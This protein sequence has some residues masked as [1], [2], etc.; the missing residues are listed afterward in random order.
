MQL[1]II[2][3]TDEFL[4]LRGE[5]N[6]LLESSISDCV[7]LTHEWLSAWWK[8]MAGGRRLS[9]LTAREGGKLI[10]ILPMAEKPAQLTRMMP[11]TVE[12]LGSGVIGSD[13]LDAIVARG[14]ESEV[15]T[16]LAGHLHSDGRMLQLS[17]LRSERSL[18]SILAERLRRHAWTVVEA[19]LNVC[20]FIDLRGHTWESYVA[21][22]GPAVRKNINRYLRNLPQTFDMRIDCVQAPNEAETALEIAVDLH[23][24]RW[25]SRGASQAF[26]S[27]SVLAFH[28][29]FVRL[30]AE[31]GWL[32]LLILRL[33][34]RP[35]A[36][37][38][39]LR[40][41]ATFYFYQSGFDPEYSKHSVGAATMGL[42]IRRAIEDGA[43]EYDFL[44]GDEEYKFHWARGVRDLTRLELHPPQT[45]A[46]IYKHA[47]ALNRAARQMARRV[48]VR[49]VRGR[50]GR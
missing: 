4:N 40:Y 27:E 33:N 9:I 22:L 28:R 39:G 46:W 41:G 16:E 49:D 1:A 34:D 45:T 20:P 17:Q 36:A 23:R 5:W 26:Q 7:F 30:A 13:Y 37:L 31:C 8:H 47:I 32:R 15:M 43:A 35:V 2:Q 42:A 19:K 48:L 24:K 44:H 18:A 12:F 11:C 21:T 29:E 14:R 6:T 10:G 25:A 50:A 38:Y 3:T